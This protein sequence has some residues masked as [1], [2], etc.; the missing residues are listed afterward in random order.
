MVKFLKK[1]RLKY[2]L[3]EKSFFHTIV[4]ANHAVM[5]QSAASCAMLK[6]SYH[7]ATMKRLQ[8]LQGRLAKTNWVNSGLFY[9]KNIKKCAK[10]V[11]IYIGGCYN[12]SINE[13][14]IRERRILCV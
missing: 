5:K 3:I 4:F 1:V 2:H 11:D 10:K 14:G 12:V 6:D 7:F 8:R 13:V 9:I